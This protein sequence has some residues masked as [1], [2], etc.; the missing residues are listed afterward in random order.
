ME[1]IYDEVWAFAILGIVV[2]F[3]RTAQTTQTK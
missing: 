3:L 1:V 2:W